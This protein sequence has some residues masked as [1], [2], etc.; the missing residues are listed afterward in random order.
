LAG[1]ESNGF[2]KLENRSEGSILRI[3][4]LR[5]TPQNDIMVQGEGTLNQLLPS[6]QSFHLLGI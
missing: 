1:E 4:I 6:V 5:L 3:E 2:K